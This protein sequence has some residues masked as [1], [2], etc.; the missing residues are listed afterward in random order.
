MEQPGVRDPAP[1]PLDVVQDLVNTVDLEGGDEGWRTPADL[2]AWL[3]AR[4][5][6]PGEPDAGTLA[7][8]VVLREA[9]RDVCS[10]HTGV[11]VPADALRDL[12]ALLA[13]APLRL[14]ADA[15][16]GARVR[17]AAGLTGLPALTAEVAAAV[18]AAVAEGTWQRLKACAADTCRW[19]YYDRS[20]AG[21]S[22][23]CTMAI[24]GSRAK[25]RTYRR[26][27]STA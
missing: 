14:V 17:P 23:W 16:G 9:L 22:R 15:E 18:S 27:R 21:R 10:A 25:M 11:D 20:P 6:V 24:C 12:N 2:A 3:R 26:R 19:V 7:A 1:A 13:A 8:A 4:G 5:I